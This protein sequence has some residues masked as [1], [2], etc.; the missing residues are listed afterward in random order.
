MAS[1]VGVAGAGEAILGGEEVDV[2]PAAGQT[3]GGQGC[4]GGTMTAA[5]TGMQRFDMGRVIGMTFGA[6]GRNWRVFGLIALIL[7]AA[8]QT[9]L[10]LF[11]FSAM[12]QGPL[13]T[14]ST[15]LS[16]VSI[17]ISLLTSCLLQAALVHGTVADLNGRRASFGDCV[18]T[19]LRF[20]APVV[21][22]AVVMGLALVFGFLLLIV[23]AV[24]MGL[25]WAV[26]IP[27]EVVERTGVFGAFSRSAD[28]TRSHR[29][30]IL[31]LALV[32]W[33]AVM[34]ISLLIGSIIA[35]LGFGAA[36]VAGG[37]PAIATMIVALIVTAAL[38]VVLGTLGAVGAAAMYYELRSIKEGIG[39]DA[40]ASVFD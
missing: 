6:I 39:P 30:A 21:A 36:F 11:R 24:I 27:A 3:A 19:G 7:A 29:W 9:L 25:A 32:Y 28:L 23:P 1:P 12:R 17:P 22:I 40:L 38:Q 8:P 18:R 16:V 31:G 35:G 33:I 37:A 14:E 26:A 5:T 10:E 34:L 13:S 2:A 15:I 4:E 20:M